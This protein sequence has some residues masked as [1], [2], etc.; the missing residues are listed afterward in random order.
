MDTKV[1]GARLSA[2]EMVRQ[3]ER[4]FA[5]VDQG[6][7]AGTLEVLSPDC[8]IVV[9]TDGVRHDGRE[10]IG[11]MFERR[12]EGVSTAWH[13]NFRHLSDTEKGWVTSRFDVRRTN[14]DGRK[15]EMDNINFFEFEGP[16]I[17]RITIWMSGENTLV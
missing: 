2:D 6:D 8:V 5:A 17:K 9:R 16:L 15:V 11:A 12:L 7:V 13:G 4:Y 10:A 1:K 14:A 3:A